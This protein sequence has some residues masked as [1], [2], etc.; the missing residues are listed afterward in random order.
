L[1]LA[2]GQGNFETLS[3]VAANILFLFKAKCPVVAEHARVPL[4]A[5][6]VTGTHAGRADWVGSSVPGSECAFKDGG[7]P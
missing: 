2:K 4:G 7:G 3:D 1:I 6:V 5:Q